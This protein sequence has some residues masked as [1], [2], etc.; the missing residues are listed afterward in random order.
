MLKKTIKYYH[1]FFFILVLGIAALCIWMMTYIFHSDVIPG[2]VNTHVKDVTIV[3]NHYNEDLEWLKKSNVPLVICSKT[4]PSPQ[5]NV[6][7]NKGRE[8]TAILKYI[9]DNYE[10]LPK[11]IAF[12]HGHESAWHH[13]GKM[14]I[15]HVIQNCAKIHEYGYISLNNHFI[16]DRNMDNPKMKH[17]HEVWPKLFEP[18]LKRPAPAYLLHDC[19]AQFIVSCERIKRHPKKVYQHWYNYIMYQDPN[20]DG[21]YLI[22]VVFE[23]LWHI[24]FGEPDVV[25]HQQ[26]KQQFKCDFA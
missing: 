6:D 22:S 21:G 13:Q 17:L 20:N 12:L 15:L 23:Y 2:E 8:A 5:C 19:C 24:I 11:H 1:S 26:Y 14:N 3:T 18:Y 7:Q 9:I 4:L 16:N 10:H 25:T